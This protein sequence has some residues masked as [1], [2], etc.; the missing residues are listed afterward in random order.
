MTISTLGEYKIIKELGRGGMGVVYLAEHQ[1]LLKKYALKVLPQTFSEDPQLVERFHNEARVMAELN[2]PNIVKVVNMSCEETTYYLVM[3]YIESETGAPKNL[4]QLMREHGGQ[5]PENLAERIA[6]D[7]LSALETAH[8]RGIIHRDI[9]PANI[10]LDKDGTA[11]VADFGL[12]KILGGD[13]RTATKRVTLTAEGLV[14]GTYDFMSPEQKA[15]KP[16]DLRTDIYAVGVIIYS[17]LTGRKPEGRF[18]LPSEIIPEL[19]NKWDIIVD[20]CLQN[21]PEDRFQSATEV[22][23][24]IK[25]KKAPK[26]QKAKKA[27]KEKK[28]HRGFLRELLRYG[29]IIIVVVIIV[30]AIMSYV[31]FKDKDF[32]EMIKS[33]IATAIK[34]GSKPTDKETP[35][36]KSATA[37]SKQQIIVKTTPTEPKAESLSAPLPPPPISVSPDL[38]IVG[39]PELIS[40][41][42]QLAAALEKQELSAEKIKQTEYYKKASPEEKM[43]LDLLL[44]FG[45]EYVKYYS[46]KPIENLKDFTRSMREARKVI[47]PEGPLKDSWD[48]AMSKFREGTE[49]REQGEV[50]RARQSFTE[51]QSEMRRVTML[52]LAKQQADSA[53]VGMENA[54]KMIGESQP[55]MKENLLFQTASQAGTDA[56][57]AYKKGDYP[58]ARILYSIAARILGRTQQEYEPSECVEI[59]QNLVGNFRFEAAS[60]NAPTQE[61]S[62][63]DLAAKKEEQARFA[64]EKKDFKEAATALV[65][66]AYLYERAKERISRSRTLP[67]KIPRKSPLN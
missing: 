33:T 59:L 53:K 6:L 61:G 20:K 12:V 51:A 50:Q 67:E 66:S 52:Q 57:N 7:I 36:K 21:L 23:Q 14:L 5:I 19:S 49:Y 26:P 38:E 63:Y 28:A 43:V 34:E 27:R 13:D 44:G 62:L 45:G 22:I 54:K 31:M 37:E 1:R 41:I 39:S 60:M 16:V 25:L 15:G 17:M 18:N 4:H 11:K 29:T 64:F 47:P 55:G 8:E 2:H 42:Q 35:E 30:S 48:K 3:E 46:G 56:N 24:A 65:E 32:R 10:L 9:K 40:A 58:R